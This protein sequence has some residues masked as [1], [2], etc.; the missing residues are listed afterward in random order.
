[1]PFSTSIQPFIGGLRCVC[2]GKPV[3]G[4]A[5]MCVFCLLTAFVQ[6]NEIRSI[7]VMAAPPQGHEAEPEPTREA[8]MVLAQSHS[9]Q[10]HDSS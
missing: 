9:T 6:V 3:T 4:G 10:R 1:M 8:L 5:G 7:S 2:V